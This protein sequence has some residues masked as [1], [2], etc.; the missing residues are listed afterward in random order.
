M[1]VTFINVAF[2]IAAAVGTV[3]LGLAFRDLGAFKVS[4]PYVVTL[5]LNKWFILAVSLGFGSMFLRYAILKA[6]GLAQSSYY[7]QT[8]LIAVYVLAY[9]VLGEQFTPRAGVGAVMIL[10][11]AFLIG[12]R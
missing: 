8:S 1:F 9:F 11:G 5:M 2:A 4:L 6:Q 12:M 7:L 10:V 3:A